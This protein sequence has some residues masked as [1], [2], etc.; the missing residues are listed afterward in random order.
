[1]YENVQ[2][3]IVGAGSV[4]TPELIELILEKKLD[5]SKIVFMDIDSER[6]E[7]LASLAKRQIEHSEM[8]ISVETTESYKDAI[9]NS[10]FILL[11]PRVGKGQMRIEDE[12]LAHKYHIPYVETVSVP[13]LGA[14]LRTV[15]VYNEI[16]SLIKEYAPNARI[17]NFA[18]PAGPLTTY[19][20]RIGLTNTVGVCNVPVSYV[21]SVAEIFDV[22]EESVSMSWKGLNHFAAADEVLIDGKNVL[23][24]L[25]EKASLG[26]YYFPFSFQVL[27]DTKLG[28]SPYFQWYLHSDERMEELLEKEKSRGEEVKELEKELLEIYSKPET[29]EM[30]ELLKKRGGFKYSEVVANLIESFQINN[31]HVHYINV[32]NNGTLSSLPDETIVEVPAIVQNGE[33]YPL[34]AGDLPKFIKSFVSNMATVYDYWISAVMNKDGS[35]LRKALM[36][37][38]V[39][40]DAKHSDAL[41]KEIFAVNEDYVENFYS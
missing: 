40:P 36:L 28:L 5:V 29:I 16:A 22:P 31:H 7:I 35:D 1:M 3:G 8:D 25:A 37:D 14:F 13:G 2:I 21:S 23:P 15:P 39:F 38:P 34:Q 9:I 10:D 6:L 30:P 19:L 33:I 18:N 17:M 32:P 11:Q 4:F 41:L 26:E 12:K 20:H 27:E 24:E